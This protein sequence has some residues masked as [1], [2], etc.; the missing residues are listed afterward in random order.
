M[1]KK[2]IMKFLHET[3]VVPLFYVADSNVAIKLIDACYAGGARVIEFTN[4]GEKAEKV[5]IDMIAYCNERYPELA[6]GVGSIA[7]AEQVDRFADL[8]A[9]FLVSPFVCEDVVAAC[10]KRDMFWT[11]GCATL[12]EMNNAHKMGVKLMKAFPGNILGPA[13]I[14]GAK[15]PCPWL[16]IMPTGGVE[17]TE[18]NLS[19]WFKAGAFC[20]GMGSQLFVKDE[21]GDY[22]YH[23][24]KELLR[25]SIATAVAN[26]AS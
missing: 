15:A 19:A 22:D 7:N 26:A 6:L 10:A 16:E 9:H 13:F 17:P 1:E 11:G 24:I 2:N 12:T 18:E 25:F 4:R 14:K 3:K 23:K 21:S 8:G 20:V 5:F